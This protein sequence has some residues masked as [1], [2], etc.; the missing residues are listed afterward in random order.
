MQIFCIFNYLLQTGKYRI[1][2]LVG[3]LP[4]KH[5]KNDLL[6]VLL[7]SEVAICHCH[8]I[9]IHHH[10]D[11]SFIKLRHYPSSHLSK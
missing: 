8:L 1:A 10:A 7:V 5:I 3:I 9:Q 2:A 11:V 4:L 6:R